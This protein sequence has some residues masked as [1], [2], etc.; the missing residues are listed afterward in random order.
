VK[1]LGCGSDIPSQPISDKWLSRQGRSLEF[2][3]AVEL[4]I[5]QPRGTFQQPTPGRTTAIMVNTALY[6]P[7]RE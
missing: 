6:A 3:A 4:Y 7:Q 5:F 2:F 1:I